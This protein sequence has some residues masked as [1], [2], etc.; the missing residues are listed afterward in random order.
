[1]RTGIRALVRRFSLSERADV[2][3]CGLTVAQAATLEALRG[4]GPMRLGALSGRLGIAPSTLTRN[5]VRLEQAG[6]VSREPDLEDARAFRIVLTTE[7]RRAA[8]RVET[9]EE[10]FAADILARL[11]AIHRDQI[12]AGLGALV[13]AVHAATEACCPGAYDHLREC[14]TAEPSRAPQDT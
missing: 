13:D 3:C 14:C 4:A 10:V 2:S 11:P 1:M 6:L 8:A 7:G 9:Q 12:L 5:L